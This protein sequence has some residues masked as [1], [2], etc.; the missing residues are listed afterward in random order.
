MVGL[1]E[2]VWSKC[3]CGRGRVACKLL[4]RVPVIPLVLDV[5]ISSYAIKSHDNNRSEHSHMMCIITIK[6]IVKLN[7]NKIV[8]VIKIAL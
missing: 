3:V 8:F 4:V 7:S 6:G 2:G 5:S 1:F